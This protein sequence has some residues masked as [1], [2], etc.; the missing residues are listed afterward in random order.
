MIFIAKIHSES[1]RLKPAE[2]FL[3]QGLNTAR[4][5]DLSEKE[6]EIY[7]LLGEI[8]ETS[9]N[10]DE[11]C[12]YYNLALEN[13]KDFGK[14]EKIVE[15]I[16]KLAKIEL[17]YFNNKEK[18]LNLEHDVLDIYRNQGYQK[19]IGETLMRISDIHLDLNDERSAIECLTEAKQIYED[20]LDEFTVELLKEKLNSL[21]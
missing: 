13:Y 20:L 5:F 11:M 8:F 21:N 15:I 16:E 9:A 2:N 1:G 14:D 3:L 6:G 7:Y 19:K 12:N 10:F 18:S 4:T 17:N